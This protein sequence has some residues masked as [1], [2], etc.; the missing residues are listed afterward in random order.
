MPVKKG[1][2]LMKNEE[3]VEYADWFIENAGIK[4]V[5]E[6]EDFTYPSCLWDAFEDEIAHRLEKEKKEIEGFDKI[7]Q[8]TLEFLKSRVKEKLGNNYEFY[9]EDGMIYLKKI[10][11]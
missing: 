10:V 4:E 5:E 8:E 3:L 7:C 1:R 9:L 11:D 6:D 2:F